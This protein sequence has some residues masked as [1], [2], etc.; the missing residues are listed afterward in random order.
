MDTKERNNYIYNR[1][2]EHYR[3][4]GDKG[5]EIVC[6]MLQGSQN[7]NLD[8]YTDEYKSDIDSKA[9][10][11]PHFRDFVRGNSPVSK[12]E[13]LENNEH[14]EVK[15][16]RIMFEMFK[17]MN[18]SYI[19]LLY[20]DFVI[21]NPKYEQLI[22]DLFYHRARIS[23]F[24][25][26]QFVKCI[27]GMALEKQKA[28][29]HPYPAT[30]DKIAEFGYDGKQ[31]SHCVRLYYLLRD[32][33]N[34]TPLKAC[35]KPDDQEKEYLI[36]LKMQ[37]DKDGNILLCDQAKELCSEY[38]RL[39]KE[40]KDEAIEEY[41]DGV[42]SGVRGILDDICYNVLKKRFTEN[43]MKERRSNSER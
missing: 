14:A 27:H 36:N 43:I 11:L 29:C 38:C 33:R 22:L 31:L 32:F 42:D 15:D 5:Y 16:I 24:N 21:I 39:I 26:S 2:V 23:A 4:L 8:L 13:V 20:S 17:K 40:L 7:Y 37:K 3:F 19:E 41:G 9:I 6:L 35:F 34:G 30:A 28:L 10:V 18:I 25:K 12:V 1:L